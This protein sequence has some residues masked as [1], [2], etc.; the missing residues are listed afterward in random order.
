[1]SVNSKMT[2]IADKIRSLLGINGKLGLDAMATNLETANTE[3]TTQEDLMEQIID[4]LEGKSVGSGSSDDNVVYATKVY[5]ENLNLFNKEQ[6]TVHLDSVTT[7]SN[8]FS[9]T[10][11][12]ETVK[13]LEV[14]CKL[15]VTDI[16]AFCPAHL[17]SASN[18]LKKL[19][20][21]ADTSKCTNFNGMVWK[22]TNLEEITGTPLDFTSATSANLVFNNCDNLKEIRFK[23]NTISC[24]APFN[25]SQL[26]SDKTVESIIYGL[27]DLNGLTSK[28]L[29]L[30]DG[31]KSKLTD[32]QLATI[33]GKNW[34]L[35]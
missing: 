29:T 3:V 16:S 32:E 33:T 7:L 2:E 6:V 14:Y 28:T 27:V 20:I 24:N 11:I 18:A 19:V 5:F 34:T 26:F 8:A 9:Q 31:V 10:V 22:Q 1:M 4:A 30:S 23:P 35:A 17:P 21:N 25:G 13:V 12:N 15:L